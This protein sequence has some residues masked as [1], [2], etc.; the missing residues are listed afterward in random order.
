[1]TLAQ[2]TKDL[3]EVSDWFSLGLHLGVPPAKLY[4][5]KHDLTLRSTQEL[6]TEMLSVWMKKSGAS[7]PRVVTALMVIGREAL[8]HKIALKYGKTVEILPISAYSSPLTFCLQ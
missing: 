7:W 2:L 4:D 6:R 1:M 8:A 5:I 3:H